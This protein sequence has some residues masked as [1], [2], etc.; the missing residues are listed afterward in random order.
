VGCC[1]WLWV[2]VGVLLHCG[3]LWDL[4]R[5]LVPFLTGDCWGLQVPPRNPVGA[6]VHL[7]AVCLLPRYFVS[8]S[9]LVCDTC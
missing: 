5:M 2:I 9:L 3:C 7:C 1:G 6:W 8:E 4:A